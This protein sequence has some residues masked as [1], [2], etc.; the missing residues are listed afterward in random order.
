[1]HKVHPF[2]TLTNHFYISR[3]ILLHR[4]TFDAWP[5][6][7]KDAMRQAVDDAV[8]WQR[9]LA[10][11]EDRDARA[12]IE[13]AGGTITHLTLGQHAAFAAAVIPLL[14]EARETY[15]DAMRLAGQ[16]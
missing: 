13:Q 12:A 11:E 2:H 16:H 3:P 6:A 10:V 15:G 9:E 14:D 4:P 7:L 1:V 8:A 5:R